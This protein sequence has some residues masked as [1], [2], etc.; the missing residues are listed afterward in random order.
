MVE[1]ST[2]LEV[3]FPPNNRRNLAGNLKVEGDSDHEM[4]ELVTLRTLKKEEDQ[5]TKDTGLKKS[6]I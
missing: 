4:I 1:E 5:K 3:F 2:R 6:R